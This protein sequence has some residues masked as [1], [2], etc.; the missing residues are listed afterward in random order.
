[1]VSRRRASARFRSVAPAIG[2]TT[3]LLGTGGIAF[4][5]NRMWVADAGNNHVTPIPAG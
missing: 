5:G 1:M 4:D 2:A 3:L